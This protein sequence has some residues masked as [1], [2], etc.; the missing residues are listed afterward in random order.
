MNEDMLRKLLTFYQVSPAFLN[1]VY[2]FGIQ[3]RERISSSAGFRSVIRPKPS[4]LRSTNL[5][6]T[7]LKSTNP[8]TYVSGIYFLS[9][10]LFACSIEFNTLLTHKQKSVSG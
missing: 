7:N 1:V 6:S 8:Q 5:R 3:T 10:P 9:R 4:N 2:F